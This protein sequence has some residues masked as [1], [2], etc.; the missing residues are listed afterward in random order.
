MEETNETTA[1]RIVSYLGKVKKEFFD[2]FGLE[3]ECLYDTSKV[4]IAD[5]PNMDEIEL[6]CNIVLRKVGENILTR[7]QLNDGIRSKCRNEH[8]VTCRYMFYYL[9]KR[10]GY[11]PSL[12]GKHIDFDRTSAFIGANTTSDRLR[13]NDK[14]TRDVHKSTVHQ[15]HLFMAAKQ[16]NQGHAA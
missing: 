3:L 1:G 8:I 9:C 2:L 12:F 14:F 11:S 7:S 5:T 10:Y 6:C 13:M 4:L 16:K 15:I